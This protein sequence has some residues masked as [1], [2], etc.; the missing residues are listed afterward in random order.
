LAADPNDN[1]NSLH[2]SFIDSKSQDK[3][4]SCCQA[5]VDC[6]LRMLDLKKSTTIREQNVD[7]NVIDQHKYATSSQSNITGSSATNFCPPTW[8]GWTCW[9][10][11]SSNRL[12]SAQC[13][14]FIYFETEPP[15]CARK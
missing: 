4:K 5:A 7:R 11:T 14:H 15:A 3:W 2:M 1:S 12:A 6:C 10:Q 9:P 13:P 8:D